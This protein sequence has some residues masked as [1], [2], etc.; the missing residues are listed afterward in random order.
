MEDQNRLLEFTLVPLGLLILFAYHLWLLYRIVKHPTKTF[1]GVNAISRRFWVLSMMEDVSKNGVLAVQTLRNNIMAST[2]LASTAVMLS[3]LIA[4]LMASGKHSHSSFLNVLGERSQFS[5]SVKYFSILLCF[6]TTFLFNVQSVRYFSHGSILINVPY[7]K[8]SSDPLQQAA[9]VEYVAATINRG[10]IFWSIGLRAFYFSFPIYLWIFG[11]IPM[12][13]SCSVLVFTLYILDT[14]ID[15]RPPSTTT[16]TVSDRKN[17]DVE[18]A[19][20]ETNY[21]DHTHL[22]ESLF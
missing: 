17:N 11:P 20:A 8:M 16:G 6:L 3:S 5:F 14:P 21:N 12:F 22:R 15:F 4:I 2:L 13:L 19:S 1:I 7:K 18:A 10:G 9:T